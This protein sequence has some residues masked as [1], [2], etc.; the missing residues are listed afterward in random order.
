MDF[1]AVFWAHSD[2]SNHGKVWYHMLDRDLRNDVYSTLRWYI[3]A[4]FQ[5]YEYHPKLMLIAG[6]REVNY[7]KQ[8][9]TNTVKHLHT[10]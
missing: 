7:W 5:E 8:S 2:I 10:S 3:Q 9:G 6:W 1:V 4:A